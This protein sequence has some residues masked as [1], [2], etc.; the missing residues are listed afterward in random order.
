MAIEKDKTLVAR[1]AAAPY[2][3]D[4]LDWLQR[5]LAT[6]REAYE[7]APASEGQRQRVLTL[8]EII[9]ALKDN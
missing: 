2:H 1:L 5:E 8:R 7:T 4:L 9:D 3:R 6:E